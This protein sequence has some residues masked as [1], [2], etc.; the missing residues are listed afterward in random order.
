[1]TEKGEKGRL[2]ALL[3]RDHN[4]LGD[5][6]LEEGNKRE[7]LKAYQKGGHWRQAGRL[8]I[9]LGDAA[10]AVEQFL[11]GALGKG[12]S[13]YE[14]ASPAQAGELL[15]SA[16]HVEEALL[17]LEIGG[18]PRQAASMAVK[19]RQPAKAASLFE[20]AREYEMAATYYQ[21]VGRHE[22]AVRVLEAEAKRLATASGARPTAAQED[23]RRNL[24]QRRAALLSRLGR[25]AEAQAL[26]KPWGSSARSAK[27][28]EDAG[29]FREAAEAYLAAGEH[30]EA[31]R[32]VGKATGLAPKSLAE[33]YARTG[34]HAQAAK[35]LTGLAQ[36][37]EAAQAYE[38]AQ[39]WPEAAAQWQAARQWR[40]AAEA[41]AKTRRL[42]DAAR[43][44]EQ[45]G[46]QKLAAETYEAAGDAA[47]A[48]QA[49]AAAGQS[50][51]ASTRF[52]SIGNKS[53]A[54]QALQK[55][56]PGGPE[57]EQATALLVPLLM[58]EGLFDAALHRLRMLAPPGPGA[59]TQALD[60]LYWE[61]RVLEEM[62]QAQAAALCYQR[63]MALQR[64]HR[65][66]AERIQSLGTLAV[67]QAEVAAARQAVAPSLGVTAPAFPGAA[68][69]P[70]QEPL[71]EGSL[72]AGRYEIHAELGRGGMGQVWKAKDRELGEW[73]A[74]KTVL[75]QPGVAAADRDEERL[76]REV[77]I[78][79][80]ITHPN[81]VRVFDLGRVPGGIFI[82]M[83]FIEG[84][85]LDQLIGGKK[86]LSFGRAKSLLAEIC[87]GL[88]EAHSLGI[89][90]RDLKP[91]NVMVT[92]GRLKILDFGI[93]RAP[94][95]SDLALTR[96]GI[97]VGSPLY[98][99][100]EQIQGETLDG[101]S[102]LYALGVLAFTLL[103][104]REPFLGANATAIVL[105]HLQTPAPS[106]Q[107]FRPDT[108]P[109]W[110]RFVATLLA[111]N[112]EDRYADAQ[113]V[114]EVLAGLPG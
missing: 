98:M 90:H 74:I 29:N 52:L 66:A 13:G 106:L 40:R 39:Q 36:P 47:A 104:G 31:L 54:A 35:I 43:C 49:F 85:R 101:R 42:H 93:A 69:P 22:D 67:R 33:I 107:S 96:T 4:R 62:G 19:L 63:L 23:A 9:E 103:A 81:V 30:R 45:A 111:K 65:D 99:S 24:D 75:R 71:A 16:G 6:Y 48:A 100:P 86:Q 14:G 17:L 58:D 109:E 89:V 34:H 1:M 44:Y 105:D 112:A 2:A 55:V 82:T 114:L 78:C 26:L 41:W 59:S 61:G 12:A 8:A 113:K 5:L 50:L 88:K 10:T 18:N 87:E 7:A 97:A 64:N 56:K 95:S 46:D 102:D 20:R 108:P 80:R 27:L 79:R 57:F 53:A 51:A 94:D 37:A 11:S 28:Q 77:Q 3:T 72:L 21:Q 38:N 60:R 83:E 15:A 32:L 110:S 25:G 84:K 76:V 91:G 68:P 70:A 73:V 92:P